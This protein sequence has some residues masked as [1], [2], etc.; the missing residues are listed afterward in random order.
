M[1][2]KYDKENGFDVNEMFKSKQLSPTSNIGDSQA[3][4]DLFNESKLSA[5]AF[6]EAIGGIDDAMLS[7]LRT[8]KN[9]EAYMDGFDKH[10][11]KTNKSIGLT[12]VKSKLAAVGVGILNATLS[13]GV[14][15]IAGFLVS[16][17]VSF[18]DDIINKNKKIA[19]AAQEAREEIETLTSTFQTNR[20]FVTDNSKRYAE[21]AQGV[22]QFTGKNLNLSTE[23]Y[24]EFLS[25]SSELAKL[26]PSLSRTYTDNGDAIVDLKGDVDGI[27]DSIETL[28]EKSR[29]LTNIKILENAPA[30][31]DDVLVKSQEYEDI[32]KNTTEERDAL[33]SLLGNTQTPNFADDFMQG[34]SDKWLEITS[35]NTE[36]LYKTRA[37]YEDL[38]TEAGIAFEELT[39]K[40]EIKDGIEV[41]VGFTFAITSSDEEV[42]NSKKS[43]KAKIEDLQG[44]YVE[45]IDKLNQTIT[46]NTENNKSNWTSL[47]ESIFSWLSTDNVYKTF[48]DD[49]QT[50]VQ[51]L[52]NNIDWTALYDEGA[53]KEWADVENYVKDNILSL[54]DDDTLPKELQS[55]LLNLFTIDRTQISDNDYVALYNDVVSKIKSYFIEH[56]I[57]I[58]FNLDF[59]V[60]DEQKAEQQL[61]ERINN[62]ARNDFVGQ[63][64]VSNY[65]KEK[66]IDTAEE[67][68]LFYEKT[69]DAKN[70]LDFIKLYD[71]YLASLVTENKFKLFT[72]ENN[73]VI[74]TFQEK[75]SKTNEYIQMIKDGTLTDGDVIDIAQEMGLDVNE[76]DLLSDS[77]KGLEEQ[78]KKIAELEFSN[79]ADKLAVLLETGQIDQETYDQLLD[80]ITLVK[81]SYEQT[82]DGMESLSGGMSDLQTSF[83]SLTDAER[84]YAKTG[85]ISYETVQALSSAYP[86]LEKELMDYLSG[87]DN[88]KTIIQNLKEAYDAD[89]MNYKAYYAEKHKNDW[90]FYNQILS[91]IP[92]NVKARFEEYKADLT[93]FTSLAEAKLHIEKNLTAEILKQKKAQEASKPVKNS[94]RFQDSDIVGTKNTVH[95]F[96]TL[97]DQ[98]RQEAEAMS[99]ELDKGV[100]LS[101]TLPKINYTGSNN[102]NSGSETINEID[103]AANS[104]ENLTNRING[105]NSAIE[106][107]PNYKKQLKLITELKNAQG[108]LLTLRKN[109]VTQY[110][111][112]YDDSLKKLSSSELATYKPLIESDTVLS[113][114]MFEGEN[115]E[116]VFERV[117]AAQKAWQEYQQALLDYKGQVVAVADTQKLEYQ[118]G[119]DAIQNKIDRHENNKSNIKNRIEKQETKYGYADEELYH[120]LLDQNNKL[121]DDYNDKLTKA[122]AN[123]KHIAET[124]GKNSEAYLEADNEVQGLLDSVSDL[125]Q[126]QVELNRTILQYP[127]HMYE[128]AK[129]ELE[130]QLEVYKER[131]SNL[132]SAI[133]GA[134]NILQDEIDVYND[135]KESVSDS[136]DAQIKVISDKKDAL[137]ETNDALKEQMALEQA[138]YNLDRALNQKTVKVI[139]NKQVVYEADARAIIDA[140]KQLDE[141]KYNIAV[142]SFD[143]QIKNLEEQK[144]N[145]LDGIDNQI[146]Q[147]QD[148]K[149]KID[150]IGGSY[151]RALE[152]QSFL[153]LFN[154]DGNGI[155]K[156]LNM[157]ESLYGDMSNQYIDASSDVNSTEEQIKEIEETIVEIEKI[158]TRWD[159]AKTTIKKARQEIED[160]LTN[161]EKELQAIKDRNEAAKTINKQWKKV[162]EKTADSLDLI[163]TNQIDSKDAEKPILE[164]RLSNIKTFSEQA[165]SYLSSVSS[166]IDTLNSKTINPNLSVDLPEVS[167][168]PVTITVEEEKPNKTDDKKN[169]NNNNKNNNNKNNNNKNNNKNKDKEEEEK[170]GKKKHSGMENGFVGS[171]ISNQDDTFQ[172]ITLTKLKP[173]EV[174]TVLQVGEGVLTKLQQTNVLDNMRT[175]FYAGIKLPNFTNIQ[176]ANNLTPVP[177]ITL[178]GD[179]VLQGVNNTTEFAQ[180]IKSEFLTKLSQ[181]LYK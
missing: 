104:I 79:L 153:S 63:Q 171:K 15:L 170:K 42:E 102:S 57:T 106:N 133:S 41:P 112:R 107:E 5:D 90:D 60:V 178:N 16:G 168:V 25:L 129:E 59:L 76:I 36:I 120:K 88:G 134:S 144:T 61:Q 128:D 1:I 55:E 33:L 51:E 95:D 19:E 77:Y 65:M 94:K 123:R 98:A 99:A 119:Q 150:S 49:M 24:D 3:A 82:Y 147:L 13:A 31:F 167:D 155:Q 4:I 162:Q 165:N 92:E 43:I 137:T 66:G 121:L 80:G 9:G 179:I 124:E 46:T 58:P 158:A 130:E 151:E 172:Y 74:D 69:K 164:E 12:G 32:I 142:S 122:K 180:K 181:E 38:L 54:F 113:L 29:E 22:D 75:L 85:K 62:V 78:L 126:E 174:P 177:S 139:R 83:N 40:Y 45:E 50:T 30:V 141:E 8:C 81:L 101:I 89:L 96:V 53:I 118:T 7:Y 135:L 157:D 28:I 87:V 116:K 136:Y 117:S 103:W 73:A 159:G 47:N 17:I 93:N 44:I 148:Y 70:A 72:E 125:K 52:A 152:L 91:N 111:T 173:D 143:K 6:S 154:S 138:Q 160:T 127:I 115:R 166:S 145:A 67:K 132:E 48:S 156:L 39:P 110:S 163:E 20:K 14:S 175:A 18:L 2:F 27:V 149:E 35:D 108:D 109:A 97:E 84:E 26:F 23:E 176:K 146:E 100:E 169:N 11:K 34:Y 71:E 140:Q 56:G 161:T 68:N 21:L 131:Q 37:N 105:L 114:E 10:V 64:N 86:E